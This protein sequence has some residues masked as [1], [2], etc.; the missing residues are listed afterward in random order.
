MGALGAVTT[1]VLNR[2][3]LDTGPRVLSPPSPDAFVDVEDFVTRAHAHVDTGCYRLGGGIDDPTAASPIDRDGEIDCSQWLLWLWRRRKRLPIGLRCA[4]YG[5]IN[6]TAIYADA[7]GKREFFTEVPIGAEVQVGD[8]VVYPGLY[9]GGTRKLAGHC[10]GVISIP[11]GF[12]YRNTA[13][14]AY[15]TIS[16]ANAGVPPAIDET[17]GRP[18]ARKGIV[19]RLRRRW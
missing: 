10:G 12:Y 18:W 1:W 17:N 19:V 7:K 15:L 4:G 14:L 8:G 13:A 5:S 6:T 9:D 11:I 16:H 3:G 2:A